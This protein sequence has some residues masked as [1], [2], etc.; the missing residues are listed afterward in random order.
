MEIDAATLDAL[1]Y[2]TRKELECHC[3]CGRC[4][5]DAF[6]VRALD[7]MRNAL[8]FAMPLSSAYRCPEHNAEVSHTHRKD[9][10]HV[11]GVAFDILCSG[12]KAYRIITAAHA[13]GFTRI[14]VQQR[15]PVEKRFIHID[16]WRDEHVPNPW[17][18]SY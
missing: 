4:E 2:F 1:K 13:F 12:D 18:W 10:A 17:V 11:R 15:G 14:G 6:A 8:G 5:V 9:G 3:G 16:M 7:G